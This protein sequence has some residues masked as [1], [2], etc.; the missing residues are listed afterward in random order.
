MSLHLLDNLPQL[1]DKLIDSSHV[2][3]ALD[4]DGTLTPIV[5]HPSKA[6]LSAGVRQTLRE[7]AI[8]P[9]FTVAII[10]GREIGELQM[11]IGLDGIYYAG[12]HG[13]E[14]CGPEQEFVESKAALQSAALE[15]YTTVLADRV[16]MIPG[17]YVEYKGLSSSV[18]FRHVADSHFIQLEQIFLETLYD[19][20]HAFS[21]S[22]GKKVF[23][24]RPITDWHKG[25]AATWILSQAKLEHALVI[26]LGDDTTDEEAFRELNDQIT[27]KVGDP[28]LTAAKYYVRNPEEVSAFL[29]WLN[30]AARQETIA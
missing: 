5:E 16:R 19:H 26:C 9:N 17:A 25:R 22:I 27:V 29:V 2:M 18:H 8:R 4:F 12:N 13:F 21:F 10:S 23:E 7:I 11:L 1:T 24:I 20:S 3:L 28:C 30:R 6:L 14:I 15:A